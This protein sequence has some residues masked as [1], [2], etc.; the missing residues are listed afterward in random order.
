MIPA[1]ASLLR[2]P[3]S[4]LPTHPANRADRAIL[5]DLRSILDPFILSLLIDS[6]RMVPRTFALLAKGESI[7]ISG[8]FRVGR[9]EGCDLRIQHKSV[10]REHAVL[11]VQQP[12]T[13]LL[14]DKGGKYGTLVNG[15]KVDQQV[16]LK[17]GDEI[18]FGNV[19]ETLFRVQVVVRDD[20]RDEGQQDAPNEDPIPSDQARLEQAGEGLTGRA[21]RQAEIAAMMASLDEN[22]VYKV[23]EQP[24]AVEE[25]RII[26]SDPAIEQHRLPV[27]QNLD[28]ASPEPVTA[29][30]VSGSRIAAGS[31]HFRLY[32]F[33][34]MDQLRR[35]AFVEVP[36]EGQR[37]ASVAYRS[38][39][40]LLATGVQPKVLDRNGTEVLQFMRGDMYVSNV[41]ETKGHQAAVTAVDWHPLEKNVAITGS[42]DGSVRLWNVE[43]GK[44][45]LEKL[46]NDKVFAVKSQQ[47]RK[48]GVTS[49]EYH[50]GG[51]LMAVGTSCGSVQIWNPA[52]ASSRPDKGKYGEDGPVVCVSYNNDGSLLATR[53]PNSVKVWKSS[54]LS[55]SSRPVC[56]CRGVSTTLD[57]SNVA[58]APDGRT[59]CVPVADL[60]GRTP[61]GS[62]RFFV[63]DPTT[64]TVELDPVYTLEL[65]ST[66]PTTICWPTKLNQ[67]VVGCSTGPIRVFF[68][69]RWSK[70]GALLT[71]AKV[72]RSTDALSELLQSRAPQGSA[73]ILGEIVAPLAPQSNTR[74]RKKEDTLEPERPAVHK[75]KVGGQTGGASTLQQYVADQSR[76]KSMAGED[77][78]VALLQYSEGKSYLGTETKILADK[79]AEEEEEELKKA[80]VN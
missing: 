80:G 65:G 69:E 66:N 44:M 43:K 5:E 46:V 72:G 56:I 76:A 39:Q 61:K 33:A 64:V 45:F 37:L 71:A 3:N 8:S 70:K 1:F 50:P 14:L 74:K 20:D 27:T 59:L 48:T 68:D 29:L 34:G 55:A 28:L 54:S 63:V 53:T 31:T 25:T 79:T 30:A 12:S 78:R 73:A 58:W 36:L 10:S 67:I 4:Q 51:R 15:T 42:V 57:E 19:R 21:K 60:D 26:P 62:L 24:T 32:D 75:H 6:S 17:E 23:V 52:R 16:E 41:L 40:L 49:L 9:Q 22:P 2:Q 38:D 7:P 13:L 18:Q 35:D 47:G 77:P 11:Q